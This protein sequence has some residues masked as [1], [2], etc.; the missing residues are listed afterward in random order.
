ML[1]AL[2]HYLTEQG[3]Q[4]V[5]RDFMPDCQQTIQAINITKWNH[6]VSSINDGTGTHYIQIQC[7][8]STYDKAFATCDSIFRLLDSGADETVINL[9][10]DIFCIARP[11]R[12]TILYQRGENFTTM[13]CEVA[14]WGRN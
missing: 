13:Y 4:N 8:D 14:L 7:R 2:Q 6:T 3:Y 9:T 5:Y 11:R 1:K 12:G 10:D